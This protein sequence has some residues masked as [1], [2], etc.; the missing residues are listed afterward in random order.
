VTENSAFLP[1]AEI[2][3]PILAQSALVPDDE[4]ANF[5]EKQID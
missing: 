2:W 1:V 3:R 4:F 5:T